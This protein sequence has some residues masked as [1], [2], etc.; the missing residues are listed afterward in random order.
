[1]AVGI[2]TLID[3]AAE[4]DWN[5]VSNIGAANAYALGDGKSA[6]FQEGSLQVVV[7]PEP[8]TFVSLIF[9]GIAAMLL[10]RRRNPWRF[11]G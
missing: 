1:V 3:G 8:S 6:Y 9:G 5:N 10:Y 2:Y 11:Q 7:V 4:I